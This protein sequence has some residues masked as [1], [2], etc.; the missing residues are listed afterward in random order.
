VQY[1]DTRFDLA[2]DAANTDGLFEGGSTFGRAMPDLLTMEG[3]YSFHAKATC[4]GAA[5][6]CGSWSG[7]STWTSASTPAGPR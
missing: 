2:D 3:N 5:P 6:G 4:G 1:V 7:P